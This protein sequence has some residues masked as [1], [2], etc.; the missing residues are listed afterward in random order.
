MSKITPIPYE[1]PKQYEGTC[2]YCGHKSIRYDWDKSMKAGAF[3]EMYCSY[4]GHVT[5]HSNIKQK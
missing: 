2:N 1:E 4:C 5:T 3:G